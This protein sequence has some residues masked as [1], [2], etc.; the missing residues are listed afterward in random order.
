MKRK[1]L[2]LKWKDQLE[3]IDQL[4]KGKVGIVPTETVY[5]LIGLPEQTKKINEIKKSPDQKPLSFFIGNTNQIQTLWSSTPKAF[6]KAIQ[7]W[8]GPFTLIA[9]EPLIGIRMPCVNELLEIINSTGPLAS[10]SANLS[11]DPTCTS[12][13][14][15]PNELIDHVDFIIDESIS[16]SSNNASTI[17]KYEQNEISIIREGDLSAEDLHIKINS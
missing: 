9:G 8:P 16:D 3:I 13:D 12:L 5:G 15:M 1:N 2:Y 11:G 7:Q 10:T 6:A 17:I 14:Q 4:K